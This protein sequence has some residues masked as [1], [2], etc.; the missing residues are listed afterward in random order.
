MQSLEHERGGVKVYEAALC[1]SNAH[2]R[3]GRADAAFG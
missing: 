1:H 3:A 2:A